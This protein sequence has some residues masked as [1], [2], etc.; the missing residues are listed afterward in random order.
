MYGR[1]FYFDTTKLQDLSWTAKYSNKDM[2]CESYDWFL[3]NS[4]QEREAKLS[5][6][7]KSLNEKYL[8]LLKKFL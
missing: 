2:I 3:K 4:N 8:W 7:Q 6:H 5:A 1:S